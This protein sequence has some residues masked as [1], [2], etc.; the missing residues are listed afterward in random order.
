MR[1]I[2]PNCNAQYEVDDGVIPETGRDVQCSNCGRSWFQHGP[3]HLP[4]AE[5]DPLPAPDEW[6]AEAAPDA[7]TSEAE[8]SEAATTKP[9]T[10][11]AATPEAAAQETPAA[12]ADAG[13]RLTPQD[14]GDYDDDGLNAGDITPPKLGED[15]RPHEPA[16]DDD[17]ADISGDY[18]APSQPANAHIDPIAAAAAANAARDADLQR[19][20]LDESLLAVLREEADRET[21]ARKAEGS[22]LETQPDLGLERPPLPTMPDPIKADQVAHLRDDPDADP[23]PGPQTPRRELL[24]NIED[25]NSTLVATSDRGSEPAARD[26]PETLARRRSGFRSG[27]G[28]AMAVAVL[29]LATYILAPRL[30]AALPRAEPVLTAYVAQIDRGRIWLDE[31]MRS[32]TETMQGN[33][34]N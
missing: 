8:T 31:K 23:A 32:M 33:P 2:C 12:G 25:I 16:D 14:T 17:D 13:T 1:L 19:R 28:L 26:A 15:D 7:V 24:P 11:E 3:G 20:T 22:A 18:V 29:G 21:R 34:D 10:S 5:A 6:E 9:E 30:T 4:E 27:F